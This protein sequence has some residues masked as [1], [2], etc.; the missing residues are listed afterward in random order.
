MPQPS[1]RH[2]QCLLHKLPW[3]RSS[4]WTVF[5]RSHGLGIPGTDLTPVAFNLPTGHRF[6]T[7][8]ELMLL[9]KENSKSLSE[10]VITKS[11]DMYS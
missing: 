6:S 8:A 4:R 1:Q 3:H 9:K 10:I 11:F 7:G 5:H 2:N